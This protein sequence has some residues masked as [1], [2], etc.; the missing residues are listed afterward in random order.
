MY[1]VAVN[2]V[3]SPVECFYRY[4][5][6]GFYGWVGLWS[7]S[8]YSWYVSHGESPPL[9]YMSVYA[10][11][12]PAPGQNATGFIEP[13]GL[14]VHYPRRRRWKWGSPPVVLKT[15]LN[16]KSQLQGRSHDRS[17]P[18]PLVERCAPPNQLRHRD[19]QLLLTHRTITNPPPPNNNNTNQTRIYESYYCYC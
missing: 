8:I 9:C 10:C 4:K 5:G 12:E 18:S 17:T 15:D 11:V 1:V 3:Y 2:G 6:Q 7:L 14:H 13:A 16:L 19:G